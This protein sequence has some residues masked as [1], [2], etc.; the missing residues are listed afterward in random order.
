[1]A[2]AQVE[3]IEENVET[4][5]G[6]ATD[7]AR[8]VV[9]AGLGAA[10]TVRENA[11][12]LFTDAEKYTEKLAEKG[13]GVSE[14]RRQALTDFVEP[15]QARVRTFG[16]E[17]EARFNKATEAVLTRLNIPTA[18]SIEDLNKKIAS[19]SRKVDKLS[20]AK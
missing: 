1:M 7:S 14:E 17:V 3:I 19:L 4:M 9:H 13:Y 5:V 16:E 8:R 11:S 12:K 10:A 6:N 2:N 15:Y 20:K 18:D